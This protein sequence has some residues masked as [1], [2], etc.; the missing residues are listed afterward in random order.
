MRHLIRIYTVCHSV[1]DCHPHLQQWTCPN[2]QMD[3]ATSETWVKGLKKDFLPVFSKLWTGERDL[4]G[5]SLQRG[6]WAACHC[7]P[8]EFTGDWNGQMSNYHVNHLW[9]RVLYVYSI[10]SFWTSYYL[11]GTGFP[12]S[13]IGLCDSFFLEMALW[14]VAFLAILLLELHMIMNNYQISCFHRI[15]K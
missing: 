14:P 11:V 5:R 15:K 2:S 12:L 1:F 3:E 10:F 9:N 6:K 4:L 13:K 8:W 7:N